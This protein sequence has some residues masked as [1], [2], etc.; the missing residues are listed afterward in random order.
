MNVLVFKCVAVPLNTETKKYV[1]L[2]L[3]KFSLYANECSLTIPISQYVV[4][5]VVFF[6]CFFHGKGL[7]FNCILFKQQ[8]KKLFNI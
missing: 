4:F 2:K 8:W 5:K 7:A 1:K 6:C 3:I